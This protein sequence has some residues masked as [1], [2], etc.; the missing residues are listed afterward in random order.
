MGVAALEAYAEGKQDDPHQRM[1]IVV[2]VLSLIAYDQLFF[3][4]LDSCPVLC[5]SLGGLLLGAGLP[6][7]FPPFE[8]YPLMKLSYYSWVQLEVVYH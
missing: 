4:S 3:L 7:G 6:A 1:S 2:L 8:N 5:S